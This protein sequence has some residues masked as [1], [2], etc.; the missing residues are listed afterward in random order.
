MYN[1]EEFVLREFTVQYGAWS[2][3]DT[4]TSAD[5][6]TSVTYWAPTGDFGYLRMGTVAYGINDTF[7]E[8]K[9]KTPHQVVRKDLIERAVTAQ[10]T[11]N[12][13]DSTNFTYL[14][15]AL[16]QTGAYNLYWLGSDSPTRPRLGFLFNGTKVDGSVFNAAIWSGEIVTEDLTLTMSGEDYVDCAVMIQAF[17][18]PDFASDP[19]NYTLDTKCYGMIF[20]PGAG[21]SAS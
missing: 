16:V 3:L 13:L 17:V 18:A 1:S 15:N 20:E 5:N 8:Y 19:T 10:F 21:S 14:Y 6:P 11:A 9:S 4:L 7:V 12:Q 2:D